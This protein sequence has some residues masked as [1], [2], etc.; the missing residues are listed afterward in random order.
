MWVT[1]A[2]INFI[3]TNHLLLIN[4]WLLFAAGLFQL[5]Y[6]IVRSYNTEIIQHWWHFLWLLKRYYFYLL[7]QRHNR[8]FLY[9][10]FMSK[11]LLFYCIFHLYLRLRVFLNNRLYLYLFATLLLQHSIACITLVLNGSLW[12]DTL[13]F[14][15]GRW[16]LQRRV[17]I[18]LLLCLF[19][20]FARTIRVRLWCN[21]LIFI[22]LINLLNSLLFIEWNLRWRWFHL[23]IVH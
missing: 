22:V 11:R 6:R 17:I 16:S 8:C 18:T 10:S 15:T 23:F 4:N 12:W 3:G 7:S 19:S 1:T 9:L 13:L 5:L 20:Q 14:L 21:R 2:N